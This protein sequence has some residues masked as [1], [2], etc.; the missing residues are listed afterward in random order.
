MFRLP[1]PESRLPKSP[2][3]IWAGFC[4]S[5]TTDI[6]QVDWQHRMITATSRPFQGTRIQS[7]AGRMA[8]S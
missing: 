4:K 3:N 8:M 7:G 1:F 5:Y 6:P 2:G